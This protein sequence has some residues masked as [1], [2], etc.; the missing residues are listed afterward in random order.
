M[1][2]LWEPMFPG[3][4]RGKIPTAYFTGKTFRPAARGPLDEVLHVDRW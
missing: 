2:V 3:D 4:S 1:I